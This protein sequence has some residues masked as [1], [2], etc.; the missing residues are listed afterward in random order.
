MATIKLNIYKKVDNKQVIEKTYT[1]EG[2]DIM[3][4]TLEDF[5]NIIDVDKLQDKAEVTKMA[6]KGMKKIK[7]LLLD[8]FPETTSEELNRTKL[9]ELLNVIIE[10]CAAA[11]EALD[12]LNTGKN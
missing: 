9:K 4:G 5:L 3:L 6:L 1:A 8:I 10:I 7:P 2:Y 11:V 12:L